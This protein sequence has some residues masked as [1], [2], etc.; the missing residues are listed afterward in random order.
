MQILSNYNLKFHNN[1]FQG[2]KLHTKSDIIYTAVQDTIQFSKIKNRIERKKDN[3]SSFEVLKSFAGKFTQNHTIKISNR[4]KSSIIGY[5]K[6]KDSIIS[7]LIQPL[8]LNKESIFDKYPSSI[9][10]FGPNNNIDKIFM[11]ITEE[12][13]NKSTVLIAKPTAYNFIQT[14]FSMINKS[15]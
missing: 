10:I 13:H 9:L 15:K 8:L 12:L 3:L 6:N 4:I 5:N 1:N 14:I 2:K 7:S 11:G